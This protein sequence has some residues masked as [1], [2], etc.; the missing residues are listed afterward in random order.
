[1]QA[2]DLKHDKAFEDG[3]SNQNGY[4]TNRMPLWIKPDHFG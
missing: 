1:M 2:G 4:A 3:R